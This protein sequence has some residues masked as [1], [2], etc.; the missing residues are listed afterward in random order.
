[1]EV[2]KLIEDIW[3]ISGDVNAGGQSNPLAPAT[4][5]G[6]CI[7]ERK[8]KKAIQTHSGP[9]VLRIA[10]PLFLETSVY[11]VYSLSFCPLYT[12]IYLVTA[13]G[14]RY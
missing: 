2:G 4:V 13:R 6:W 11:R 1:M 14:M 3:R 7:L 5:S 12:G 9:T 8:I 10:M